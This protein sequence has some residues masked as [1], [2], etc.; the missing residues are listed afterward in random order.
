MTLPHIHF[1]RAE[2]AARQAR[3]REAIAAARLDGLLIF[4]IEDMYWLTGYDSLGFVIFDNMF[5]G[6]DGALTHV[7]RSADLANI[8]YSSICDDVRVTPDDNDIPRSK[9]VKDMLE[10]HGMAGK[11]IGIQLDTMGLTPRLYNEM[12]ATLDGWCQ[13]IDAPDMIRELR[14]VKSSQELD[15]LR[16]AGVIMDQ[17]TNVAI[18]ATRPG[19]YEGDIYGAIYNT[20]FKLGA[21]LPA[22]APP[23]GA[24]DAALN[25][26]YTTGRHNVGTN[27]QIT[28]E[29]AVAYRHYHTAIMYVVLTGPDIDPRHLAMHAA[30]VHAL[31]AVQAKLVP[32]TALGEVFEAHRAA[33]AD[34]G[35]EHASLNAC[36]YTMGATWSPSWMEQ[37]MIVAGNPVVIEENM[38]FFTHMICTDQTTGLQ[39][40]LGEQS[41]ITADGPEIITHAP[42][43]PIINNPV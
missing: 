38:N 11:R 14:L 30:C 19:A 42:R 43:Q 25:V 8:K 39:M 17:V 26:R 16:K 29:L 23:L 5:V 35:L 6:V 20:L 24:G 31:D 21:D 9:A 18:N 32:G 34:H 28:H 41:I 15:Y 12:R 40:A 36:G 27:D 1:D 10:S 33:F 7:S 13:L 4:K 3:A 37:P 2:F 22:S